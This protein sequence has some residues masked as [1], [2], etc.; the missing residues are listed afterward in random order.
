MGKFDTK[1][2]FKKMLKEA[3]SID[4]MPKKSV[5]KWKRGEKQKVKKQIIKD[6]NDQG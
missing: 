6:Q 1:T 3:D 2:G 4:K 5:R